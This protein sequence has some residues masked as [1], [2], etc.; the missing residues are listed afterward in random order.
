MLY[1]QRYW[2]LMDKLSLS[3]LRGTPSSEVDDEDE[4][5]V[6]AYLRLCEDQL[7]LR[8]QGWLTNATWCLWSAGMEQQLNRWP[9]RTVRSANTQRRCR[10]IRSTA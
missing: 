2:C 3:A 10:R 5:V 4:K 9:F 8:K 6:R 7:E 1:V